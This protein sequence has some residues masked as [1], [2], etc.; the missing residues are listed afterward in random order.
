MTDMISN[1]AEQ[2]S[3]D[4]QARTVIGVFDRHE[5]A[6]QALEAL[7]SAGFSA[8]DLSFVRQGEV[9]EMNA[10]QTEANA[11]VATGLAT[12][13]V[14]GGAIGLLALAIPGIGP[15]LAVGPLVG[16][17]VG[18]AVGGLAGSFIGLGVPTEDARD[19]ESAVRNGAA[20]VTAKVVGLEASNTASRLLD[21]HGARQVSGYLQVL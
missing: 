4:L 16:A 13:A 7:R 9:P 5:Q 10:E 14:V 20:V 11:G 19:Y 12:G 18:G 6:Q 3:L 1:P 2:S 8:D 17:L 21:Q 15:L